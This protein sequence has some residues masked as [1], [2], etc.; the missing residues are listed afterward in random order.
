[1]ALASAIW[2]PN[3][4]FIFG[5]TGSTASVI[6]A[7]ILPAV[8]FIRLLDSS[9]ELVVNNSKSIHS[10]VWQGGPLLGAQ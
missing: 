2:I 8:I 1:M 7:Y 9:P 4:E 6:M 3:L 10:E 5:L